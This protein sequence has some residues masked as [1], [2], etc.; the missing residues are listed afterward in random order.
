M[1]TNK[2]RSSYAPAVV[3]TSFRGNAANAMYLLTPLLNDQIVVL[4]RK[5]A[6]TITQLASELGLNRVYV[7][8]VINGLIDGG[9]LKKA[10]GNAYLSDFCIVPATS[11]QEAEHAEYEV[12]YKHQFPQQITHAL[13]SVSDKITSLAFYGNT[14]DYNYLLWFLYVQAMYAFSDTATAQYQKQYND[15]HPNRKITVEEYERRF[16]VNAQF[17]YPE[18]KNAVELWTS[19][20]IKKLKLWSTLF[21]HYNSSE[22]GHI[23]YANTFDA[24]PFEEGI[25]TLPDGRITRNRQP[26]RSYTFLTHATTDLY[27]SLTQN[28]EHYLQHISNET[29]Q[30]TV[31]QFL[32]NGVIVHDNGTIPVF[33]WPV[34]EEVKRILTEAMKPLAEEFEPL[35]S[36]EVEKIVLPHIRDDLRYEFASSTITDY[37]RPIHHLLWYGMNEGHTLSLPE[38]YATSCAGL[39]IVHG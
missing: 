22:Y 25:I 30:E 20:D 29:E 28:P 8:D 9:L 23:M 39:F 26:K 4:C 31:K 2:S 17:Y 36:Y 7:E 21:D 6:Q 34:W 38:N 15:S 27:I 19:S 12:F 10:D 33:T 24:P 18:E 13:L 16:H 11:C 32:S 14:F 35:I 1:D 5:E 3:S 37:L